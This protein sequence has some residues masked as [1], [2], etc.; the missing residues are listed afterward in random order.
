M[1][2]LL[3]MLLLL[4]LHSPDCLQAPGMVRKLPNFVATLFEALM[5]FLLDIEDEPDWHRVRGGGGG[6]REGGGAVG[7]SKYGWCHYAFDAIP[8]MS[9]LLSCLDTY[10]LRYVCS[11]P[12]LSTIY[13]GNVSGIFTLWCH[14]KSHLICSTDPSRVAALHALKPY[15]IS[16][17][18]MSPWCC[19]VPSRLTVPVT[20][21]RARVSCL[22]E[23]RSSSTGWPLLW[24]ER[25]SYQQQVRETEGEGK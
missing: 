21:R 24:G 7:V 14:A 3:F 2:C 13:I 23:G 5:N 25:A 11:R 16:H 19:R 10:G 18:C 15:L 6:Q 9:D 12:E 4:L 1:C 17:V 20:S 8:E 22:M